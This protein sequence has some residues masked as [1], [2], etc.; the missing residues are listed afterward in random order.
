MHFSCKKDSLP[1]KIAHFDQNNR[2]KPSILFF[3]SAFPPKPQCSVCTV[4]PNSIS[5]AAERSRL[6]QNGKKINAGEKRKMLSFDR[7]DLGG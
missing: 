5:T 1:D 3:F 4:C 7:G 6:L 2:A